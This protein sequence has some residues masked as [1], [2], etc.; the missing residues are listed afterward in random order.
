[1]TLAGGG[2]VSLSAS[3]SLA[4]S[5]V[6][7]I[8]AD[9]A[10]R[11][12]RNTMAFRTVQWR[13]H[14]DSLR[15]GA[16]ICD[17]DSR[18]VHFWSQDEATYLVFPC[19]GPMTEEFTRRGRT[20]IVLK[21]M[22]PTWIPTPSMRQRDPTLPAIVHPGPDNPLGTRALNLSWQYYRIHGIDNV[23][24]IGRRASNGCFGLYNHHVEQLY[25]LVRVGTQVV[26]L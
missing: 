11:V 14:F 15:H 23:A 18:A 10:T 5:F 12:R 6:G 25:D 4:Q 13:D 16:I 24:K 26:V 3:T 2:L 22:H 8:E 9:A 7:E 17:S 1:M 20:E 21:R 19:S